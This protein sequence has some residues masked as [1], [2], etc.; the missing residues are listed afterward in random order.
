MACVASCPAEGALQ[1]SL[2][3]TR[4]FSA[5]FPRYR[6]AVTPLAMV[7]ILAVLFFGMILVAR[8]SNHWQT[9]VPQAIY[10]ELV[11]NANLATHPGY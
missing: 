9:N 5:K 11:P 6:R 7:G 8:A 3:P 4:G 2:A 1:F 10:Q